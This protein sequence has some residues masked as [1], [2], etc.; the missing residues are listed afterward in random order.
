MDYEFLGVISDTHNDCAKLEK[1]IKTF[2][3]YEVTRVL[4]CGDV[5]FPSTLAYLRGY[6]VD[7]VL[8]NRDLRCADELRDACKELGFTFWGPNGHIEWRGHKIFFTHGDPDK[9]SLENA[10]YSGEWDLVCY[11]HSHCY[12]RQRYENTLILNPG[13]VMCGSMCL[14]AADLSEVVHINLSDY[15]CFF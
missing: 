4:H 8:G 2:R 5:T 15:G 1:A 9:E 10:K 6:Q 3:D 13:S 14:V 11:G 12:D 7:L